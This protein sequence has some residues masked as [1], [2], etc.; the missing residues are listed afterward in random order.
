MEKG[1]GIVSQMVYPGRIIILGT[2]PAGEGVVMYAVT[3]RSSSSQARRLVREKRNVFVK[4]LDEGSLQGGNPELLVYPAIMVGRWKWIAV[5]NG[6]Q[7][8]DMPPQFKK[9]ASPIAVMGNAL[10][11]WDYE[12]DDPNFTPRI[13]GC[14]C[15]SAALSVIRRSESGEVSRSYFEMPKV[16]GKGRLIATYSGENVDP[17]PAFRGEPIDIDIEHATPREAA[18]ALYK[19]LAPP[20][21]G[22][23]FRVGVAVVYRD[24][25]G[26]VKF[27]IKNRHK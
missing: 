22:D 21:G 11:T 14:L 6:K 20:K 16:P 9:G 25:A 7:T 27:A 1:I 8:E 3:G 24:T 13:S 26:K 23:D 10:G 17:L 12:P 15:D 4:P 2:S 18:A 5:S 19:A